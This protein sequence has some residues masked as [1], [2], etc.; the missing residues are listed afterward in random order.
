MRKIIDSKDKEQAMD[1][2]ELCY[3]ESKKQ[4]VRFFKEIE[5]FSLFGIFEEEALKSAT[6][7]FEY[8]MFIREQLF[9]CSGIAYVMTHPVSRKKGYVKQLM[10][11][12]ILQNYKEGYDVSALWPFKHSFYQKFG[13]E[14]CEKTITYKFSPSNIK[15]DFK[16]GEEIEIEDITETND[17]SPLR[18][19]ADNAANKYTRVVGNSA[20]WT[21]R[22]RLQPPYKI[23][24]FKRNKEPVAYI[25]FR[26][27]SLSEWEHNLI[28]MDI[29][30]IDIAAKKTV[31]AFLRKFEADIKNIIVYFPYQEEI[32]NYLVDPIGEHKFNQWPGMV[33]IINVKNCF[34]KLEYSPNLETELYCKIKDEL[35]TENDGTW[36]LEISKQK[37][38]AEKISDDSVDGKKI[39]DITIRQLAQILTGHLTIRKM[40]ESSNSNIPEEWLN[41][42]LFPEMSCALMIW[43]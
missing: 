34:Q 16:I 20:A 12:I 1:L 14:S 21:V 41:T 8:K 38:I 27:R 32:N 35:I 11:E 4:F 3:H 7:F 15:P 23:F 39:L 40:Y 18:I 28:I 42:E 33:R 19:I 13:Y 2:A 25:S 29:A 5:D 24:L 6:G 37:C 10:N 43:F 30:F 17:F 22:G 36:K 31:F 26:F 9:R